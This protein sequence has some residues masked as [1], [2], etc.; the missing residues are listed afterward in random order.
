MK[1]IKIINWNIGNPS[2]DRLRKQVEYLKKINPDI[3]V[4]TESGNRE[5]N[6]VLRSFFYDLNYNLFY[7]DN[8]I[9]KYSAV[10]V[11]RSNINCKNL[12][13]ER[14]DINSRITSIVLDIYDREVF[15]IGTYFPA[16]NRKK[17]EKKKEHTKLLFD[18][19]DNVN[20][21]R[22]MLIGDFNS[23]K[24]VH[25]PKFSWFRKWEYEIFD[26]ILSYR[27]I[28]VNDVFNYDKKLYS[29]YGNK[30]IGHLYDYTYMSKELLENVE[31]A[32]FDKNTITQKLSDHA[33][34][35][36]EMRS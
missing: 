19:L 13:F 34:Q 35:I 10:I 18:V 17:I 11:I 29:W 14:I 20:S 5:K 3:M 28:D 9:D 21:N 15:L 16:N 36:I 1:K 12:H 24:R 31:S 6:E 8:F 2:I 4:L 30:N 25:I 27:L 22:V 23:V 26:K 33:C 7:N 32:Y